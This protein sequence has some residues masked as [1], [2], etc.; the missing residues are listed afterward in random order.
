MFAALVLVG[1][2]WLDLAL[3]RAVSNLRLLV[4]VLV[5]ERVFEPEFARAFP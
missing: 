2:V 5:V 4:S 3:F 1:P